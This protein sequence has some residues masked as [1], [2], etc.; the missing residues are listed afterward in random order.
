MRLGL[1]VLPL[2]FSVPPGFEVMMLLITK[3]SVKWIN[4]EWKMTCNGI[5]E[6]ALFPKGIPRLLGE[7]S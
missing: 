7:V 4:L 6:V 3:Y 5:Q 1:R 2:L